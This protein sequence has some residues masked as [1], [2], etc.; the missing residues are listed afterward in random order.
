VRACREIVGVS[1][2]SL[3]RRGI[4]RKVSPPFEVAASACI[5]CGTCVLICPTG[6]IR[7]SDVAGYR[8]VHPSDSLYGREYCRVCADADL[9]PHIVEDV[10]ALPAASKDEG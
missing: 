1:A 3:V 4:A 8:S 6:A 10:G 2:I 7:L 9:T 5:G